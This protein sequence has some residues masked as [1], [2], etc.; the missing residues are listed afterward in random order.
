MSLEVLNKIPENIEADMKT[1]IKYAFT[2][3]A[4]ILKKCQNLEEPFAN[5]TKGT[6]RLIA[7][8]AHNNMKPSMLRFVIKHASFF[9]QV[10]IVTT[11][12]TGAVLEKALNLKIAHKVASGPLGGDQQI[13]AMITQDEVAGAF[14]FVDPLTSHPHEADIHAL[15]RICEVHNCALATNSISA[16]ALVHAFQTSLVH[17]ALLE[18]VEIAHGHEKGMGRMKNSHLKKMTSVMAMYLDQQA[19]IVSSSKK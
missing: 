11:G 1:H 10:Q 6:P 14:F 5:Q 17:I 15:T 12:S 9:K 19:S 8:V 3:A 13:G 4:E 16:E 2:S 7:L 18:K